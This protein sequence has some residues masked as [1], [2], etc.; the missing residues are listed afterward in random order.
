MNCLVTGGAGF[1]GSHIVDRLLADGHP[2]RVL[3]NFS[4]GKHENLAASP[5]Y[6]ITLHEAIAVH[7]VTS[8]NTR[9]GIQAVILMG[10]TFGGAITQDSCVFR[11]NLFPGVL[12]VFAVIFLLSAYSAPLR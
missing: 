9:C 6:V 1:I 4:T 2:T 7:G 3:D 10:W 5:A 11:I 12:C 8:V